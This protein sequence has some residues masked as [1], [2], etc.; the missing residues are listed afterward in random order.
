MNTL[1]QFQML[2]NRNVEQWRMKH[3]DRITPT[4]NEV[5]WEAYWQ[6]QR[7]ARRDYRRGRLVSV[8]E[9]LPARLRA[10]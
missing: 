2:V 1:S 10:S 3:R 7:A 8:A 9:A 5:S 6:R 4:L